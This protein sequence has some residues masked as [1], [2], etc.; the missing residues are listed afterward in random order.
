MTYFNVVY[1]YFK[2]SVD[3]ICVPDYVAVRMESLAQLFLDWLPNADDDD[4]YWSMH[5]GKKYPLCGTK[6]FVKWLNN[7]CCKN[8]RK[9]YIVQQHVQFVDDYKM[10]DF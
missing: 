9:A 4:D 5:G 3:I 6:G 8:G 1:E 2:E 10:I 7:N